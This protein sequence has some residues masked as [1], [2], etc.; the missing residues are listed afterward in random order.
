MSRPSEETLHP[1]TSTLYR[2]PTRDDL[3]AVIE[4]LGKPT[5][6]EIADL[7]GVAERT[8]RRWIAAPTAKTRTQIDYAAWRL[9]LLEAGLVRIHTRRSRS[10]NKEKAR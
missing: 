7:V 9:L 8:I 3:I 5:E 1:F 6:K 2:P 10:R 4:L